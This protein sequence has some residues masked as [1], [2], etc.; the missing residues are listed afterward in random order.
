[1][2]NYISVA[3]SL[4]DTQKTGNAI[5]N[6]DKEKMIKPEIFSNAMCIT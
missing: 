2:P 5:I 4:K 3:W 6:Q 1:M